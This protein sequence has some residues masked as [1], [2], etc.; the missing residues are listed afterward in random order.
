MEP[1]KIIN[2]VLGNHVAPYLKALGFKKKAAN[3]WRETDDF[4]DLVNVQK[5]QWN[6]AD[7]AQFTLNLGIYWRDVQ[8]EIQ[9]EAKSMP[10]KELECTVFERLGALFAG[11]DFWWSVH[12]RT[13]ADELGKEVVEKLENFGLPWLDNGHNPETTCRYL[14]TTNSDYMIAAMRRFMAKHSPRG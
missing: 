14:K 6:S 12:S 13:N 10:P 8:T 1:S 7:E 5:S 2:D 3:F 9:R 4:I 11:N